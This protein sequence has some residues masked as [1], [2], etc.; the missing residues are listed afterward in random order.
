[1]KSIEI[2]RDPVNQ[3][4]WEAH[5]REGYGDFVKIV[6]DVERGI[7]GLGGA[8]HADAE[9]MLLD[10]GSLQEDLWGAN[11]FLGRTTDDRLEYDS[12]INIRPRQ[13]NR[14]MTLQDA[15]V[16]ERVRSVVD[17]LLL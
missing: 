12:F 11:V 6:V 2:I 17:R 4:V 5:A 16:C 8:L 14:T 3:E 15:A 13:D 10:N 1:M 9:A 7:L